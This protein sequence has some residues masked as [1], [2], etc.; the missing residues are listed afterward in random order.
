MMTKY[1]RE[2]GQMFLQYMYEDIS[3]NGGLSSL[4]PRGCMKNLGYLVGTESDDPNQVHSAVMARV[5]ELQKS[6]VK[7]QKSIAKMQEET[8]MLIAIDAA[9]FHNNEQEG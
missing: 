1:Q 5:T 6:I 8:N 9:I 4:N 3:P 7:L 2:K